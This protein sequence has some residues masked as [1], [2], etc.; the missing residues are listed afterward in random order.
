MNLFKKEITKKQQEYYQKICKY[1][2]GTGKDIF[3]ISEDCPFCV[4][5]YKIKK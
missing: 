5:P 1:C 3:N 2:K 4:R